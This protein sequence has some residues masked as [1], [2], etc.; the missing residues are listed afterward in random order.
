MFARVTTVLGQPDRLDEGIR[1]FREQITPLVQG[2][3]GFQGAYLLVDRERGKALAI[4]LWE[5]E[6]AMQQTEEA[7]AQQRTQA[8]QQ[9]GASTPA[10]ERYEVVLSEGGGQAKAARVTTV[11]GWGAD[12]GPETMLGYVRERVLPMMRQSSGFLGLTF[13]LDRQSS[14]GVGLGFFES[15][16][17]LR[18][19]DDAARQMREGAEREGVP[20]RRSAETYEVAVQV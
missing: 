10:V 18:A 11:E 3:P 19:T 8:A 20:G 17:A 15:A 2:Q 14:K 1:V 4:S 13:L 9:M 5:S 6:Q 16:E 12:G 7:I